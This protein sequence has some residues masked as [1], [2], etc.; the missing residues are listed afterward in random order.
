MRR[1]LYRTI[2]MIWYALYSILTSPV[3]HELMPFLGG[4]PPAIR[5]QTLKDGGRW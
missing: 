2:D 1:C 5:H 3:M 4:S